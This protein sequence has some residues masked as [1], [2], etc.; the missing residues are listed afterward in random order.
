MYDDFIIN[1]NYVVSPL[2]DNRDTL[3]INTTT[4]DQYYYYDTANVG[5]YIT[6]A[7]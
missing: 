1:Y 3:T 6:P 7:L 5:V 4:K 2:D